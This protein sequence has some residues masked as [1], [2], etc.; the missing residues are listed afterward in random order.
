MIQA[1]YVDIYPVKTTDDDIVIFYLDD[2]FSYV[3]TS[4]VFAA[5]I[6]KQPY[7]VQWNGSDLRNINVDFNK[8]SETITETEIFY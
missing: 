5:T 3:D 6:S 8:Y 4:L 7:I 1:E 2:D